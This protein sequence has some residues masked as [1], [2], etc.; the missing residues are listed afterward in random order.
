MRKLGSD[1]VICSGSS[2]KPVCGI[3]VST[4]HL[5]DSKAH[6]LFNNQCFSKLIH[7]SSSYLSITCTVWSTLLWIYLC[8]LASSWVIPHQGN[9]FGVLVM[10]FCNTVRFMHIY[11][12]KN[13]FSWT[14]LYTTFWRTNTHGELKI[15]LSESYLF[16]LWAVP[17]LEERTLL[18]S[19]R[20]LIFF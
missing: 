6:D 1:Y 5:S 16:P 3:A 12:Y 18:Q 17:P 9:V 4:P 11:L 13:Y 19:N 15:P 8:L 20:V 7:V 10:Y 2:P 14:I